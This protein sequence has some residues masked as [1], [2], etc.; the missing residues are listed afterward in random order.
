MMNFRVL[1]SAFLLVGLLSFSACENTDNPEVKD[2]IVLAQETDNLST[3]V[4]AL[5]QTGL[6][7]ALEAT[8][9]FTVFAPTNEAFQDL[10]DSNAAWSSLSDI[11]NDLLTQ[12]LLFHVTNGAVKAADLSDTYVKTL[13]EGPNDETIDL[14]I[15]TTG[16]VTFNGDAAPIATDIEADNGIIHT[17]DKVMLPP[18]VVDLALDNEAFSSL[19]AAL[20]RADLTINFVEI[21]SGDGPFTVFAPTN[22]AFSALLDSNDDWET[23]GDI[24]LATLEAVLQYHVVNAAN[25]Q[26]DQLTN[27]QEIVTLGGKL[28]I[29]LTDGA[30]IKTNTDQTVNIIITDVQGSNGVVHAIDAVL[31]P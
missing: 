29:D 16:G 8:G 12:V 21:L 13:S 4:A 14:R 30:K 10:L 11:D 23:L 7:S 28:L 24:P 22:A 17:I 19:V 27:E 6:T 15:L 26:A 18:T 5:E 31:L 25:V 9:P 2:I 20:T 3:L 1:F